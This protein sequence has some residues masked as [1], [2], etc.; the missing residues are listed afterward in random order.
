[1]LVV[2]P[3]TSLMKDQVESWSV[4][5]SS[6]TKGPLYVQANA[7][8]SPKGPFFVFDPVKCLKGLPNKRE[9]NSMDSEGCFINLLWAVGERQRLVHLLS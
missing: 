5:G 9:A 6:T 1:M 8:P 3:V 4:E 2:S 7:G